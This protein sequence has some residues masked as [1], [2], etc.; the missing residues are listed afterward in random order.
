MKSYNNQLV[1]FEPVHS[2]N[3]RTDISI[4]AI[5]KEANK[6]NINIAFRVRQDRKSGDW[7]V[8]DMIAEGISLISSKQSEYEKIIRTQGIDEV[9]AIMRKKAKK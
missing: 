5:I 2:L 3:R 4:K 9:I 6:P 8:Y 7:F 1:E